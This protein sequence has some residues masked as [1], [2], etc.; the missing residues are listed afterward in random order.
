M[1]TYEK[2][3][4][5]LNI[6]VGDDQAVLTREYFTWKYLFWLANEGEMARYKYKEKEKKNW[7]DARSYQLGGNMR[8]SGKS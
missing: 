5:W 6:Q 2:Q 3:H 8:D 7:E 1:H 4:V